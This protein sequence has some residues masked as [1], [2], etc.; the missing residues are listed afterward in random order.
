M[1]RWEEYRTLDRWIKYIKGKFRKSGTIFFAQQQ[2]DV[3]KLDITYRTPPEKVI[4]AENVKKYHRNER[5]CP[6]LDYAQVHLDIG[7]FEKAHREKY[8]IDVKYVCRDDTDP[9]V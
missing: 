9:E 7:A 5:V 2:T 3:S 1:Q 4:I 6:L 8:M